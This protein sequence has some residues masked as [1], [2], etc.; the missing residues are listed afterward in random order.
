MDNGM[1]LQQSYKI[2]NIMITIDSDRVATDYPNPSK[3]QNRPTG[4]GHNYGY[5][6]ATNAL[7]IKGQGTG[8]LEFDANSGDSLRIFAVSA[9]NNSDDSVLFYNLNQFGGSGKFGD[10]RYINFYKDIMVPGSSSQI[11]PG[12]LEE[13]HFWFYEGLLQ[14]KGTIDYKVTFALY[15][16]NASGSV[17]LFGYYDWDPRINVKN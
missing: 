1:E 14:K 7:G 16:R 15:K 12:K 6:V 2:I 13:S 11:L 3:D 9:S 10:V 8:D 17:E 4:I 5:M